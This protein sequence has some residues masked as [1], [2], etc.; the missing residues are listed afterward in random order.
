MEISK[1]AADYLIFNVCKDITDICISINDQG[2][3]LLRLL[4]YLSG[5]INSAYFNKCVSEIVDIIAIHYKYLPDD[6]IGYYTSNPKGKNA[7]EY[8]SYYL[9]EFRKIVNYS[10]NMSKKKIRDVKLKELVYGNQSI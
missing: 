4:D 5:E 1:E 8:Y 3:R 6:I 9:D 2:G 7:G 10:I